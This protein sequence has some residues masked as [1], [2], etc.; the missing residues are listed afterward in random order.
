MS[1]PIPDGHKD[2]ASGLD[3]AGYNDLQIFTSLRYDT[4]LLKSEENSRP[5]LNFITPSPFYMLAY[6][7]DRLVEA[8]Q[9]FEFPEVEKRL[10]DG[11]RLHNT[12]RAGAEGFIAPHGDWP[13]HD[14][15]LKVCSSRL[16]L[17]AYSSCTEMCHSDQNLF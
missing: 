2:A 6:H 10:Q 16:C 12:L 4:I 3:T 1:A 9:H 13:K 14:V 8:A 15:A 17:H 7:R 11:K 5:D